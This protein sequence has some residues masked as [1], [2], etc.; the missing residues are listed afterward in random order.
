[1]KKRAPGFD[2]LKNIV[3]AWRPIFEEGE[4]AE[5]GA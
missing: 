1:L 4:F 2:F 5:T 3:E